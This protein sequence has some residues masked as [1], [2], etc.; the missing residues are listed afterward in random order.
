MGTIKHTHNTHTM[1]LTKKAKILL[2]GLAGALLL[3]VVIVPLVVLSG[4]QSTDAEGRERLRNIDLS[5]QRSAQKM[6][7]LVEE[8]EAQASRRV[9]R[10][11]N[12]MELR[13][14][15]QSVSQLTRSLSDFAEMLNESGFSNIIARFQQDLQKYEQ[16]LTEI[17]DNSLKI[18]SKILE[19]IKTQEKSFTDDET[20]LF[21]IEN[22]SRAQSVIAGPVIMAMGLASNKTK[23]LLK[24]KEDADNEAL[25]VNQDNDTVIVIP[26][27]DTT[28][29]EITE[30]S[31]EE[32]VTETSTAEDPN[33]EITDDDTD[34]GTTVEPDDRVEKTSADQK[35]SQED[36]SIDRSLESDEESVFET[37][38][39]T[40]DLSD[41]D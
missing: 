37:P 12:M 30:I 5:L 22:I 6:L 17:Q 18:N 21:K 31:T 32:I 36:H 38:I 7:D 29:A 34:D 40:P 3:V 10:D 33:T 19:K 24:A 39:Q 23:E 35:D 13:D 28:T 26:T 41:V 4:R 16:I 25:P 8:V 9:A 11:V 1:G 27:N 14:L 20:D 2:G 15:E